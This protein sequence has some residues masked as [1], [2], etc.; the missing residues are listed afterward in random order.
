M[1][2]VLQLFFQ[3]YS[4][5]F[6]DK[7]TITS[8][9]ESCC[10]IKP[11]LEKNDLTNFYLLHLMKHLKLHLEVCITWKQLDRAFMEN[12]SLFWQISLSILAFQFSWMNI[13]HFYF[14]SYHLQV[15]NVS[16]YIS[17]H[18]H[19][20]FL[21]ICKYLEFYFL[22]W[23]ICVVS[24]PSI[25]LSARVFLFFGT[26]S[27]ANNKMEMKKANGKEYGKPVYTMVW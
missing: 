27:W 24:L 13:G 22:H 26:L 11:Q 18:F 15:Q 8:T 6:V 21:H 9:G 14:H 4:E 5:C 7:Y 16:H 10:D 3:M 19:V 25:F 17:L 23:C 12:I 2:Y 20:I 1:Y